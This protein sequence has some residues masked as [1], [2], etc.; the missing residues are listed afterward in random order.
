MPQKTILI[1]KYE[2]RR[3]YDVTN[4]RYVNLEDV[5]EMLR[6]GHDVSVVDAA[7]G[8]DIT[9]LV[10]T[11][12]IIED[13]KAPN[14][15]FPLD[16][17]RQMIVTSGRAS[18]ETALRYMKAML[19]VYQD[20]YR[21]MVPAVNPFAVF[22]QESKTGAGANQT[23]AP[24]PPR[25]SVTVAELQTEDSELRQRVADLEKLVT[26]LTGPQRPSSRKPNRKKKRVRP[27]A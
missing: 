27:K 14:S 11:Q 4:S 26:S 9:R 8:N 25:Q 22:Q 12:I 10:L 24:Q 1:R 21:A 13:A 17:L 23:P 19:D 20:T 18:Q 5:A 3:L 6:A 15:A 7:A 2:N 16:L